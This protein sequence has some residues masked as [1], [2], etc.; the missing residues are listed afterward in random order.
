LGQLPFRGKGLH[1]RARK[2]VVFTKPRRKGDH[3]M[4]NKENRPIVT[5]EFA[6]NPEQ[7]QAALEILR[8]GFRRG[9]QRLAAERARNITKDG[10]A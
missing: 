7:A 2:P 5:I 10:V 4:K 3:Y 8:A 9:L 6:D 1:I